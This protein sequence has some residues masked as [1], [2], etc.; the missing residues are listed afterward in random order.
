MYTGDM[1]IDIFSLAIGLHV[2]DRMNGDALWDIDYWEL[3]EEKQ[4]KYT[5]EATEMAAAFKR[6]RSDINYS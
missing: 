2:R 6:R 4:D 1:H 3:L 5:K